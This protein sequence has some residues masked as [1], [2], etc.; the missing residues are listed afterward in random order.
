M[1]SNQILQINS[2]L[3]SSY[4]AI[5]RHTLRNAYNIPVHSYTQKN[6]H[7]RC[8]NRTI[9][10]STQSERTEKLLEN[11][12]LVLMQSQMEFHVSSLFPCMSPCTVVFFRLGKLCRSLDCRIHIFCSWTNDFNL[13]QKHSIVWHGPLNQHLQN[14]FLLKDDKIIIIQTVPVCFLCCKF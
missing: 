9:Q 3:K 11:L 4:T 13:Y 10:N 8:I 1:P 12:Y 2:Y 5:R 14:R 7:C 6:A